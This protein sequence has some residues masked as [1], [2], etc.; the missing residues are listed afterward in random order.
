MAVLGNKDALPCALELHLPSPTRRV[1]FLTP[2][3][4]ARILAAAWLTHSPPQLKIKGNREFLQPPA[5]SNRVCGC[6]AVESRL[7]S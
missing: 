1:S 6:S 2:T 4:L 5:G 3:L 7:T